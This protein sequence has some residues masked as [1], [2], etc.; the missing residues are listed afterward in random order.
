MRGLWRLPPPPGSSRRLNGDTLNAHA[1]EQHQKGGGWW[2]ADFEGDAVCLGLHLKANVTEWEEALCGLRHGNGD[3]VPAGVPKTNGDLL[4]PS[5]GPFFFVAMYTFYDINVH[6]FESRFH[7]PHQPP[8]T[9][10]HAGF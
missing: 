6:F 2:A 5:S 7:T 3:T 1:G 9:P 8:P 4:P 10:L